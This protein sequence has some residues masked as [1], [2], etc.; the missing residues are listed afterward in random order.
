[1]TTIKGGALEFDIIADSGLLDRALRETERRIQGFSDATVAGGAKMG[2]AFNGASDTI[3]RAFSDIDTMANMHKTALQGLEKEYN[4]LG[5]A[6]AVAFS[7]GTTKGD[8]EYRALMAKQAAVADEIKT[9]KALLSEVEATA[10][11]LAKE[12]Q[13]LLKMKEAVDKNANAQVSLR[14][15]IKLV[16]DEMAA[17]VNEAHRNNQTLDETTGR[18]AALKDELGRLNDI[19]LDI[20]QQAKV[21]A[22]DEGGFQGIIQGMAGLSGAFSAAQGAVGLFAG[23]NENLQKIMMKVQSAMAITV[24]LQQ[25]AQTLNKDSAFQLKTLGGIKQWWAGVLAK[26]TVSQT[27]ETAATVANTAAKEA[28]AG[29]TT[30]AAGAEAIHTAATGAQAAAATAGT[31]ANIGLAG[32]FRLVGVAIKSIPVIGWILAGVSGLIALVRGFTKESREAKK[33]AA[34]FRKEVAE[35]AAKPVASIMDLSLAWEKLGNNIEEKEK[36]IENNADKFDELGVSVKSVADAEKLLVDG[37][38]A[39]IDAQIAKAEAMIYMQ[40]N[41]EKVAKALELRAKIAEMSDTKTRLY[42]DGSGTYEV[43]NKEKAK[44]VE[45]LTA[46]ETEIR[47]GYGNAA[48]ATRR[49]AEKMEE[50]GVKGAGEYERGTVGALEQAIAAKQAKLKEL[51][52]SDTDAIEATLK[53]I[54]ALQK[55]VDAITG[56]SSRTTTTGKTPAERFA[57]ELANKKEQYNEYFKWVNAGLQREAEQEFK[58]LKGRG[59]N[60]LEFLKNQRNQIQQAIE[61][62]GRTTRRQAEQLT[63]LN[64]EIASETK[65]TVLGEFEREL[66][67]QLAGT[68]SIMEMLNLLEERRSQLS[69]DGSDLDTGKVELLDKANADVAKQAQAET[70][71]LLQQYSGY[72]AKKIEFDLQYGER[73]KALEL[74]LEKETNEERRRI[75]L[76]ALAG[77]EKDRERY[78]KQTGDE[79]YDKLVEEY[80]SYQQKIADISADFDKKIALATE[81]SNDE[82]VQRLIEAKNEAVSSVALEELQNSEAWE[83]LFGNL[84]DLTAKQIEELIAKIEAQKAQLGIELDPADYKAVMDNLE[85][86]K[87]EIRERN[88]F[89]ALKKSLK[90]YKDAEDDAAKE[91]A[92]KESFKNIAS[93]AD[94]VK[95]AFDSVVDGLE[96]MGLAGDDITQQLLS[97][98]SEMIGAVGQLAEGLASGNPLQIIQGSVGLIS[99]A[100]SVFNSRDRKAER[101]IRKHAEE[102]KKLEKQYHQLERAVDK[103]LG[104]DRYTTHKDSIENLKKQQKEYAAMAE[105]E[106]GKKKRDGA[107]IEEYEQ[108]ILDNAEKI[109]D[110]LTSIREDII[111]GDIASIANDLGNAIIDAF[112]A[113]ED[114]AAAW[115]KKVDD[116]V[117]NVIR[118]MLIQK[119]VEEPVGRVLNQYLNQWVDENGNFK[120]FD[121]V[122]NGADQLGKDL[123]SLSETILKGLESMPEDLKKYIMPSDD[124]APDGLSGAIKGASQES[125]DLLAGQTN[126]VRVNQVES[127]EILRNQLLHL[128][129]IDMKIDT[130]NGLLQQIEENTKPS[131]YDPLRSQGLTD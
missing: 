100:F 45:E 92:L 40:Q 68:R 76:N 124:S 11:A 66:Q 47:Q 107:K 108:A 4:E 31:A 106:R 89:R 18:Y 22:D 116:I 128:A 90:D 81:Q 95:G 82:L 105:A 57:E 44:L 93:S 83:Q 109:E 79:D 121:A 85:K 41:A 123:T 10:D 122:M 8:N 88:P 117:G 38:E 48:D 2:Q 120:G 5:Q 50:A 26:A 12:E 131:N 114:A 6:A 97:D 69:N 28:Q 46:L 54:E 33:A 20:A 71:A 75:I 86:A 104:G 61:E 112:A 126:A 70:E 19:Q 1:M 30:T 87:D 94:L 16:K 36:F 80:R 51:Q 127:I 78:A 23:E 130:S 37:K 34:E 3:K 56:G 111:G 58:S 72:L 65:T 110:V 74:E 62:T 125:I 43:D 102:V 42:T 32:A 129:S 59:A 119:L 60:Y 103:A 96:K 39:F 53:E 73:K 49:G 13:R 21:L 113:G 67:T 14:T 99:S 118:K 98:I 52:I 9:R 64:S 101:A 27:A 29:A 17:L 63:K 115:G 91:E 24:G 7:K 15:Q 25:V 77:L 55:Q 84:D 35:L